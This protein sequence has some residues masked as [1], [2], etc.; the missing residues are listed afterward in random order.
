MDGY[1]EE[2]KKKNN[3]IKN[4]ICLLCDKQILLKNK[5]CDDICYKKFK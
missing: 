1:M 5:F 4:N 2:N 3:I